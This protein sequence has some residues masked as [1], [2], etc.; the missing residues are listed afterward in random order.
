MIGSETPTV[1]VVIGPAGSGKS[2]V[3]TALAAEFGA[4]LL[5]KDVVCGATDRGTASRSPEPTPGDE[6]TTPSIRIA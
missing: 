5:D 1:F 2:S 4:A 3:S 6:T